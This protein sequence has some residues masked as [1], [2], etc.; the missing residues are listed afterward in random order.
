MAD[1]HKTDQNSE[2][3]ENLTTEELQE[4]IQ[5]EKKNAKRSLR[6]AFTALI[7]IIAV[8]I[9]WF[10]ANNQVSMTGTQI[11]AEND[12][13]FELASVG[14]RQSVEMDKLKDNENN[15]IL[16]G[17]G[18]NNSYSQCIDIYTGKTESLVQNGKNL[19]LHTGSSGLAWYLDGQE[20][21]S[22]GAG[23]E[24]TFYLIPKKS[25][26]TEATF[27]FE[28]NGYKEKTNNKIEKVTGDEK[29]QNLLEGHILFFRNLTD[30]KGY[31]NWLGENLSFTVK[32]PK[33]S[34]GTTGE[35]QRNMPYKVTVYWVWPRYFR[36]YIY[37]KRSTE[38]DLFT[39]KADQSENSDYTKI[40]NFV[41]QQK[42]KENSKLFYHKSNQAEIPG[43]AAS[44]TDDIRDICTL[45][46][47]QAD[48]YIGT[49]IQYI[50]IQ[51]K[52]D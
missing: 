14:T 27:S 49:E 37:T 22:P 40:I 51:V 10:V 52:V 9:A 24:L 7:A 44:M 3:L 43:D 35:F 46:Y 42:S 30:E 28:L 15:N 39:D 11:S 50:Y 23:G 2:E 48:E 5:N 25:G 6:F 41:N 33:N 20:S 38:G 13:P 32:A 45:Y 21:F 19:E 34:D 4:R 12:E 16:S 1:E 47:N 8:C 29:L 17:G 36:N 18:L 31:F 26:L